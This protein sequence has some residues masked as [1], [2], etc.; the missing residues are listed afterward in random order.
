M[1]RA[2]ISLCLFLFIAGGTSAQEDLFRDPPPPP[3]PQEQQHRPQEFSPPSQGGQN[4]GHRGK[5]RRGGPANLER[6]MR[7]LKENDPEEF[8]RMQQLRRDN[9]QEFSKNLKDRIQKSYIDRNLKEFPELQEFLRSLSPEERQHLLRK[10]SRMANDHQRRSHGTDKK[11]SNKIKRLK[12]ENKKH[13]RTYKNAEDNARPEL[14]EKIK[15]NL[16]EQFD[17][18]EKDRALKIERLEK[19]LQKLKS[20][21]GERGE[22]RDQIIQKHFE[23]ISGTDKPPR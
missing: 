11:S 17:L 5:M 19:Q 22:K 10:L 21:L 1:M 3:P 13:I 14:E 18:K 2:T 8:E 12:E 6:W 15:A 7:Q 16:A 9:P 20:S 4:F 23:E